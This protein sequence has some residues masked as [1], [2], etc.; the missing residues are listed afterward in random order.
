MRFAIADVS[1][2]ASV[3]KLCAHIEYLPNLALPLFSMN[4]DDEIDAAPEI[5]LDG[6][7]AHAVA[8]TH[9]QSS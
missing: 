8:P 7:Q 5:R 9:D 4:I 6:L 3:K 1:S 2:I